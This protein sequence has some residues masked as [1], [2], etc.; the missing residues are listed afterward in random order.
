ME[1]TDVQKLILDALEKQRQEMQSEFTKQLQE[2]DETNRQQLE[3]V[4]KEILEAINAKELSTAG[5]SKHKTKTTVKSEKAAPKAPY[6]AKFAGSLPLTSKALQNSFTPIQGTFGG[7]D[8]ASV[9]SNDSDVEFISSMLKPDYKNKDMAIKASQ[10]RLKSIQ[11]KYYNKIPMLSYK[12]SDADDPTV[13]LMHNYN[14]WV[15]ALLKYFSVICPPLEQETTLFLRSIDIDQFLSTG[16]SPSEP[17]IDPDVYSEFTQLQAR[18]T[19]ESK[20]SED[21]EELVDQDSMVN[22][23]PT[24]LNIHCF[25]KPNSDDE[26]SEAVSA[27]WSSTLGEHEKI[28]TY[29]ARLKKQRKSINEQYLKEKVTMEDLGIIMKRGVLSSQQG[30]KF[31]EA[32]SMMKYRERKP[33]FEHQVIW[34]HHNRSNR[35]TQQSSAV[36]MRGGGRGNSRGNSRGARGGRGRGK[37][38]KGRGKGRKGQSRDPEGAVWND[39][40]YAIEDEEGNT[41]ITK[42][43]ADRRASQPCFTKFEDGKCEDPECPYSHAFNL[44]E[45]KSAEQK[46]PQLPYQQDSSSAATTTTT[47]PT[48]SSSN[49]TSSAQ[50]SSMPSITEIEEDPFSYAHDLGFSHTNSGARV[51]GPSF[52]PENVPRALSVKS[53]G[54]HMVCKNIQILFFMTVTFLALAT[55]KMPT[56]YYLSLM[57][58]SF[59]YFII[60]LDNNNSNFFF[61]A[62]ATINNS[63]YQVILDCGC[64]FTMSGD[65]SL[66]DE[67]SMV[68]INETVGLSETGQ[69]T[70]ATHYGKINLAGRKLDALYVP[71]IKQTMVSMGQLEKQGMSYSKAGTNRNFLTPSGDIFLSFKLST[72]N[73]YTLNTNHSSSNSN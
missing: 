22:I 16:E 36:R 58:S 71:A 47:V 39:S 69:S 67:Y 3:E 2:K 37:G 26:R 5:G 33:A 63:I 52:N 44:V 45:A 65:L 68:P 24:L 6:K 53:S 13:E 62:A 32:Y 50:N 4:S 41:L 42:P 34:L 18:S 46:Q 8:S 48:N 12:K 51:Q 61:S 54:T 31:K 60:M 20:V 66:F 7:S 38:S 49:S 11:E 35:T 1:K 56:W 28:S 70:K 10:D 40:Y 14:K 72:N 25:C 27:I 29:A 30:D 9:N 73:L 23:F 17:F 57:P 64:T 43:V 21:F 55:I 59:I 19:I 15:V